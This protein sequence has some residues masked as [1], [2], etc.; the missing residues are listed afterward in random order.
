MP[1]SR[2]NFHRS[3]IG[4]QKREREREREK[5][6]GGKRATRENTGEVRRDRE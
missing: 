3:G 4:K 5:E 2:V 1:K 6:R